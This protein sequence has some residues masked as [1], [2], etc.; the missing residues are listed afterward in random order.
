MIFASILAGGTGKRM[1]TNNTL[2][3][4][5]FELCGKPIII[6]TIEQVLQV[7][8][9]DY[10]IIAIH[11]DYKTYLEELISKFI[12]HNK[13]KIKIC[14]GGKERIDS[15]KNTLD[16]IK[17]LSQDKNDVVVVCDAVRPFVTEKIL[18]DSI[19]TASKYGACVAITPAIDTMYEVSPEG[20]VL[21]MPDRATLFCG[22][23]PDS[24]NV[25]VLE[26]SLNSLT[27]EEKQF[28][29]GTVQ[30]VKL[31]GHEVKTI[32]GDR[33]NIKITTAEDMVIAEAII[34]KK[35]R[36]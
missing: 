19:N 18:K 9:F 11:K 2:P 34:A 25:D 15:I 29:T 26:Q 17:S 6:R 23:A 30:I 5:F 12:V 14:C 7:N 24:F 8:D 31:K 1:K 36:K 13:D 3:K 27:D 33:D 32:E 28:I 21:S 10:L 20:N 4:Q 35:E 22:Q 16:T